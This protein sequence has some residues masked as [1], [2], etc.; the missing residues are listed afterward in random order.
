MKHY[1]PCKVCGLPI[2][3]GEGLYVRE[4]VYDRSGRGQEGESWAR[5]IYCERKPS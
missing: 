3:K 4:I 2:A 1:G 5:H